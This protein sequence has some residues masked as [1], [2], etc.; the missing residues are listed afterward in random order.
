MQ[1]QLTVEGSV[2]VT[3][4]LASKALLKAANSAAKD[5]ALAAKTKLRADVV[6]GLPGGAK[7]ANTWRVTVYP[8]AGLAN[9]PAIQIINNAAEIIEA[10]SAGVTITA[11]TGT[12]LAIPSPASLRIYRRLAPRSA[13]TEQFEARGSWPQAVAAT[14]GA[15]PQ[16]FI[17]KDGRRG[18]VYVQV[19]KTRQII[20]WLV[21][22]AALAKRIRG[23][24]LLEEIAEM[25]P[26]SY[27]TRFNEY[28]DAELR[29]AGQ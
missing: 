22:Q 24:E 17:E 13:A 25:L 28:L 26:Q 14:L 2:S 23:P 1:I 21:K 15:K 20:G 12:W 19:G 29:L 11:A 4:E 18:F 10:F 6:A 5:E 16:F 7:L 3:A 8:Q 9:D 27:V